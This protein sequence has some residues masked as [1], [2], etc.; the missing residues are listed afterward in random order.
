MDDPRQM[1]IDS[2]IQA[3]ASGDAYS[4]FFSMSTVDEM[5]C[6]VTRTLTLREITLDGIVVYINR[7]SPKIEQLKLN[8]VYELLLFWPSLLRQF[9]VRGR[10]EIF[11]DE[12]QRLSWNAKPYPGKL[13][14]LFHVHG[15]MQSSR[16]ASRDGYLQKA[17]EVRD[18]FHEAGGLQMPSE[19]ACIRFIPDYIES[20]YG[21]M[22]DHLHDRRLFRRQAD[23][24]WSEQVL[25]P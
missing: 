8:P 10:Y 9:R 14:D 18:R 15:L 19:N 1:L 16:L 17:A 7:E 11:E 13:Y 3:E 4:R 24:E 25:V 22:E 23:G 12:T 2:F 5:G 21:S 6:P 20:W